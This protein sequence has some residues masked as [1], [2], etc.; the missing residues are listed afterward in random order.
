MKR[1]KTFR[2]SLLAGTLLAGLSSTGVAMA[3]TPTSGD[4]YFTRYQGAPPNVAKVSFNYDGTTA[5]LGPEVAVAQVNGADGII[6]APN[7]DRM[8]GGEGANV[9]HQI[10]TAGAPV[11]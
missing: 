4:L 2:K 7:G 1:T 6:F 5:T 9:V 3:G 8:V 11:A 10:T